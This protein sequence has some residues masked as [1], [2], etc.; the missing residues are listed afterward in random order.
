MTSPG[1]LIGSPSR[2]PLVELRQ[3]PPTLKPEAAFVLIG[4]GRTAGYEMIR[5]GEIPNLRLGGKLLV[6]TAP[7]LR[8]LGVNHPVEDADGRA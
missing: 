1:P 4:V 3:L 5:R 7:L 2:V 8:L 6:L